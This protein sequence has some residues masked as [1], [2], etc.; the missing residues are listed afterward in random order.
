MLSDDVL[1]NRLLDGATTAQGYSPHVYQR[2]A[3]G[4]L[5]HNPKSALFA[6]VGLGKALMALTVLARTLMDLD[7]GQAL[8]IAPIRVVKQT[9]PT[10]IHEWAHVNWL[11]DYAIVR[12]EDQD[13]DIKAVYDN[14]RMRFTEAASALGVPP[15]MR[16]KLA[17]QFAAPFRDRAKKDK[18]V[19][20][21]QSLVPVHLI[22]TEQVE[23]LVE[24]HGKRWPY[25]TVVIDESSKFKDFE[26]K[27][28]K[29]LNKVYTRID[30]MHLLTASP[31]PESYMDLF[32]QVRL[33]DRGERLG[34]TI[35]WYRDTYFTHDE[36]TRSYELRP[37]MDAVI[38]EKIADICLVMK[39]EDYLPLDKPNMI[40]RAITLADDT[41][42][43]YDEF[44]E[45]FVLSLPEAE[46]EALNGGALINKLL[47]FTGGAVYDEN[48][49]IHE[50]HDD[51]IEDLRQLI[52]E[53]DGEPL[54][55]AYWYQ[56]SLKRLRKA[57]PKAVVMDKA[58]K[59][60]DEWNAG[61]IPLLLIHP[62][63]AGHGLNMQKG[64]GH[65]LAFFDLCWSRELY[66]QIIG[67]L[68][69]QGQKK[70]VR[71]WHQV[72]RRADDG[73]KRSRYAA[74]ERMTAD[75]IVMRALA[76][77]GAGQDAL[78]RFI[79]DIRKRVASRAGSVVKHSDSDGDDL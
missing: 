28:W 75:E 20:L 2:E 54:M 18:R 48:N 56:S 10:E 47:Q 9:W 39:A 13:P 24:H 74:D 69:R 6:D 27:R 17:A 60:V 16:S 71:V 3:C 37:G 29:A 32:A 58:G 42:R 70:V 21:A 11:D 14:Y 53:L 4:F 15:G 46:I 19:A 79:K 26:T 25:K 8:V 35:T 34:K 5:W 49:E 45:T 33:L 67:R 63:S 1:L 55:V 76:D 59:A 68:A 43:L 64:P 72:V 52:D 40:T 73:V 65:D 77:K 36:Y 66:E 38:S 30:R 50:I 12:A 57:F 51:K 44:V 22:G 61:K 23:W 41:I 62:A 7:S 31:A 78:F